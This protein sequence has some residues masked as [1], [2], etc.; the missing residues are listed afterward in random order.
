MAAKRATIAD[1]AG[2][3]RVDRAVVS[4]VLN[5]RPGL[6]VRPET[7]ERVH[8]AARQLGYRPSAA[9]RSLRM[10]RTGAIG[11]VIPSFTNPIW[12]TILDAVEAAADQ[13]GYTLLA[14]IAVDGGAG[15]SRFLDLARSGA[16]DGLLVASSLADEQVGSGPGDVPVLH[17]NRRCPHRPRHVVLDDTAGAAL[18]TQHV[19]DLG[20]TRIAHLSG[21]LD[22]DSSR[23]RQRG[24]DLAMARSGLAPA[25]Y[26][27]SEYDVS[28]GRA[29]MV[30]LLGVRP[31]PTA[32]VCANVASAAG[33]LAAARE[34][35][36]VIPDGLSIVAIHD[37]ELAA[38]LGPPLTTV[39][40]PL[41]QLGQRAVELLLDTAADQ[42]IDEVIP[43]PMVLVERVST[44]PPSV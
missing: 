9:A 41:E 15:V 32:I 26:A 17:I 29:A 2:L 38:S 23:A 27:E 34:A 30:T 14:G 43:G 31:R 6:S 39:R 36:V 5:D 4:K 8:Q 12:A 1:V 19:I 37:L 24:F 10:A 22:T 16:V 33:A 21:P 35:G 11:V 25:G 28:T 44:A 13:R 7:R 40:M 3:A 18:A 42:D 20:H